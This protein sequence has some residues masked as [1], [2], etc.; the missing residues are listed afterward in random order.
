MRG[1]MTQQTNRGK[2]VRC[3]EC[4]STYYDLGRKK[5]ACPNCVRT[6]LIKEGTI[7]ELSLRLISGGHNDPSQGWTDDWVTQNSRGAAYL[8]CEFTVTSGP[9]ATQKFRDL[10]GLHTPKGAWWGNRGRRTIRDILN[11]A[12]NLL[13]EDYSPTALAAR[14]LESLGDLNGLIFTAEIGV[15]KGPNGFEKNEIR[16]VLTPEDER[17]MS[18]DRAEPLTQEGRNSSIRAQRPNTDEPVWITK[19]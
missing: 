5:A 15:G 6:S 2:R 4:G 17:F 11:S 10:I 16:A 1:L 9:F 8:N 12:N 18:A 14:H 3:S 19:V 13:D 7:A